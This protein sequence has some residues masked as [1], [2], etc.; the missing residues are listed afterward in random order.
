MAYL[1]LPLQIPQAQV[2]FLQRF[3]RS[4]R[5][6]IVVCSAGAAPHRALPAQRCPLPECPDIDSGMSVTRRHD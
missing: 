6:G 3:I 2:N 5:P 1:S 4:R